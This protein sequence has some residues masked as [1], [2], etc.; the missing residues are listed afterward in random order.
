MS[1]KFGEPAPR[2]SKRR[3]VRCRIVHS[4]S[5]SKST[6]SGSIS[7]TEISAAN[8]LAETVLPP[9]AA[10]SPFKA[11]ITSF[12]A[13]LLSKSVHTSYRI[14]RHSART[15][16]AQAVFASRPLLLLKSRLKM[17]LSTIVSWASTATLSSDS[18]V[19]IGRP[20]TLETTAGTSK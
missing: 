8:F 3:Q 18:A 5:R 2:V 9:I 10:I 4:I 15:G 12:A 19:S 16:Q 1:Q 11:A 7:S 17:L 20:D 13:T 6:T 14:V